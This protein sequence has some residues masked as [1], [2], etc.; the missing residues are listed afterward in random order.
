MKELSI[1]SSQYNDEKSN[2]LSYENVIVSSVINGQID[3]FWND[4]DY[5]NLG[6]LSHSID[7]CLSGLAV[8]VISDIDVDND[9]LIPVY[10]QNTC[11]V[12]DII[13]N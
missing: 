2:S 12:V 4:E 9:Q 10:F 6:D 13:W 8:Y 1:A 7:N 3:K 11:R 5:I